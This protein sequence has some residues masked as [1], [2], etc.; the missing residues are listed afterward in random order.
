[1]KQNE[2]EISVEEVFRKMGIGGA[3][4]C[5]WKKK[6]SGIGPSELIPELMRFGCS[7][8]NALRIVQMSSSTYLY[9][10]VA[11]D[12]TALKLRI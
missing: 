7:Q 8:R 12:A 1:M 9:C 5:V 3:T 2:L 11:R 6:Y 4:F 10:S